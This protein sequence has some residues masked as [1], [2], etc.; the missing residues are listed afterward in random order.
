[1]TMRWRSGGEATATASMDDKEDIDA[2]P[3]ESTTA[4]SS[5]TASSSP[6][7]GDDEPDSSSSSALIPSMT[8]NQQLLGS[9]GSVTPDVI[10]GSAADPGDPQE[11]PHST[12]PISARSPQQ[13]VDDG[14]GGIDEMAMDDST[15]SPQKD[16]SRPQ[17]SMSPQAELDE[18]GSDQ[19]I[20]WKPQA[21]Q[22]TCEFTHTIINYSQKRD[23]GCKK[24]EYSAT[25]IDEFGNRWRLIVYVNGNGRASNHHLSLFLQVC[26]RLSFYFR[27]LCTCQKKERKVI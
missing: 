5:S 4:S 21:T 12:N 3:C 6:I 8:P 27:P 9:I 13:P 18:E 20:P 10:L 23:S 2:Q 19:E 11:S 7:G 17:S 22:S 26:H 14:G 24:A 16:T 1:M 25:T 15:S